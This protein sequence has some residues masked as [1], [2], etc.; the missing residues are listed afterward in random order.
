MDIVRPELACRRRRR[1]ILY[2]AVSCLAFGAVTVALLRLKPA[3]P[4]VDRGMTY[5]DTVKCGEMLR[6]VRG[7]GVLVPEE[8]NWIPAATSGRVQRICV[9]PGAEVK[10]DTV[11]VE[12]SNPEVEHAAFEAEWQ[13]KAAEA[14][15]NRLKAQL[16]SERLSEEAQAAQLRA[17]CSVAKLDAEAD[18][19]LAADKLV[20]RLT[21]LRSQTRAEQL[22][23]RCELEEKRLQILADSHQAQLA[24]ERAEVERLRAV[25]ELRRNQKA[26]LNVCSGM[27]GVLQR[28]GE[29]EP[30][31]VGQQIAA[32][33]NL[34]RVANPA[35]LKAE[36]KVVETQA[37]DIAPG[38][39]ASIDTRNGKIPGHVTRVDPA[40]QNGTVTVDVALD[41]PLPKGA[42]PDLSV[43]GVIELERLERVLYVGRP[44]QGQPESTVSLFKIKPGGREAERVRVKLGHSSVSTIEVVDGLEV[45]DTILLNDMSQFDSY[46]RV[47]IN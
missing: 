34:A 7:N 37:K 39:K 24:A 23:I 4:V 6:E 11:L 14:K 9:F 25:L 22:S 35:R 31:Q 36:I 40:V 30:L 29:K 43:E 47:R 19:K 12:L 27:D 3:A 45:G 28:L 26:R 1:R 18:G 32:G 46:D 44:V 20:D 38:Q 13:L 10:A 2:A 17:D 41:G 33:A 42:R 8:I 5:V 15:F 16:E 21:A